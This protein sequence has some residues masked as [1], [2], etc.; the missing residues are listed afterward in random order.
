MTA[1]NLADRVDCLI[2]AEQLAERVAQL[3]RQIS[4][5]Y[6]DRNLMMVGVLKGAWVFMADLVRQL[7]VPV[8]CDFVRIASYGTQLVS[9][10]EPRLTLDVAEPLEGLDVLVVDDIVD[11]GLSIVWLMD[12]LRRKNPA[13]L[14]LCALLDKRAR[15]EIEVHADYVGFEIPDRFVVGYGL[16]AGERFRELPYLGYLTNAP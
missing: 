5:D 9:S 10:G 16:D 3:G 4:A 7:S 8:R 11:T 2:S 14:R 12:H 6:E 1:A 15:R 13:S